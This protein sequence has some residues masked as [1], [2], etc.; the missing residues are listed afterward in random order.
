MKKRRQQAMFSPLKGDLRRLASYWRDSLID[1]ERMNVSQSDI[2]QCSEEVNYSEILDGACGSDISRRLRNK[3]S[4]IHSRACRRRKNVEQRFLSQSEGDLDIL[5]CP[6]RF[7]KKN[8]A[9]EGPRHIEAL[10]IPAKLS[11]SGEFIV[12]DRA[13]PWIPRTLLEPLPD[14]SSLTIGALSDF[15]KF[16]KRKGPAEG[17]SWS[18]Y[19]KYCDS[20]LKA[21]TG[22][23]LTKLSIEGYGRRPNPLIVASSNVGGANFHTLRIFEEVISGQRSPGL[24]PTIAKLKVPKRQLYTK[25]IVQLK[26]AAKKHCGQF[27]KSFPLSDSQRQAVHRFFEIPKGEILSVTGPPGTG[28]TTLIQSLIASLW[29]QA[30]LDKK[31]YPPIILASG[32]TNKAVTNIIDSFAKAQKTDKEL[33]G[34]WLPG[35]A[36]YGTF[37][38]SASK[39]EES[40]QYQLELASGDGFSAEREQWSYIQEAQQYFLERA[41]AYLGASYGLKKSVAKLRSELDI[42]IRGIAS[43]VDRF[44]PGLLESFIKV[45]GSGSALENQKEFYQAVALLDTRLRHT[46]FLLATHIWEGRWLL[47]VTEEL[48][49]RQREGDLDKRFRR[50][51]GDWQRRAMLTPAFVSTLYMAC[52]FFGLPRKNGSPMVDLLILDEA[53]QIPPELGAVVSSI[54][55]KA[56]VVGDTF[57]LEPVWDIPKHVDIANAEKYKLLRQDSAEDYEKLRRR[58]ILASSGNMM[59]LA[60]GASRREDDSGKGVFLSEHRRSVPELVAYCNALAYRGRLLARRERLKKRILP[61]FGW[62]HI[63][64]TCRK[65]GTSRL[66]QEEVDEIVRWIGARRKGLEATYRLPI[67]K[68]VAVITPFAAQRRALSSALA[69]KYPKLIVGTVNA[70]QGAEC[71][72]VIFSP[73]YDQS[74]TGRLFFDKGPNMLNVAVSRAKD[75]FLVFGDMGVFEKEG[76][77]P[78]SLLRHFLFASAENEIFDIE[79]AKRIE[80]KKRHALQRFSTLGEHQAALERALSTAKREVIIV[81]PTISQVAIEHDAIDQKIRAAVKRGIKVKVYT[82]H[83]LNRENGELVENAKLGRAAIQTAGAQ[84]IE[85]TRIHNKSLAVDQ[86][87]LIEGSFNWLSAVRNRHSRHQKLEVSVCYSGQDADKAITA[88]REDMEFRSKASLQ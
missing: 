86:H 28:K 18:K 14:D 49:R 50:G 23:G 71:P 59:D 5:I 62:A 66:N 56:L 73:T 38:S 24:L 9:L 32:A 11:E 35:I 60:I 31:G 88:L 74:H 41:Q 22:S 61:A 26:A 53:G 44:G 47:E 45:F 27:E 85:A 46:A 77:S 40:F 67:S 75:S 13:L 4:E 39:A 16:T 21:V 57:Q 20:L 82:D 17:S 87:T 19:W 37:C 65:V 76:T 83:D 54:A 84:L 1:G 34:R 43:E 51:L 36:S 8:Q 69:Q 6:L 78:S 10:W 70:L 7:F 64:G 29:V 63:G 80:E 42:V 12:P 48:S 58:G 3:L 52:R 33:G 79:P 55:E 15:E 30:A 68:I 25:S 72:I 2:L 81:S